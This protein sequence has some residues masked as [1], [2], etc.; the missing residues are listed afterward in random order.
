MKDLARVKSYMNRA[1]EALNPSKGVA[2]RFI[3]AALNSGTG[4][5]TVITGTPE[6]AISSASF[7]GKHTKFK[8]ENEKS[9]DESDDKK[10]S[11]KDEASIRKSSK[12]KLG[13]KIVERIKMDTATKDRR[14]DAMLKKHPLEMDYASDLFR[15]NCT[16]V[17]SK[18]VYEGLKPHRD[19]L[20]KNDWL[21]VYLGLPGKRLFLNNYERAGFSGAEL[22]PAALPRPPPTLFKTMEPK[23]IEMMKSFKKIQIELE[24]MSAGDGWD[25]IKDHY[26]MLADRYLGSS[27]VDV[28]ELIPLMTN[29]TFGGQELHKRDFFNLEENEIQRTVGAELNNISQILNV[30]CG[31]GT[32]YGFTSV[33]DIDFR[34]G[35]GYEGLDPYFQDFGPDTRPDFIIEDQAKKSSSLVQV[36]VRKNDLQRDLSTQQRES[37]KVRLARVWKDIKDPKNSLQL[38][39]EK[40]HNKRQ[41]ILANSE[42]A[43]LHIKLQ[44]GVLPIERLRNAYKHLSEVYTIPKCEMYKVL[45]GDQVLS[46]KFDSWEKNYEPCV[47]KVLNANPTT[48]NKT[49]QSIKDL[50]FQMFT[51]ETTAY[52]LIEHYNATVD[53]SEKINTPVMYVHGTLEMFE[54]N[55]STKEPRYY[56]ISEY[57]TNY[58][59]V[60]DVKNLEKLETQ[61]KLLHR[62]GIQHNAIDGSNILTASQKVYL[63]DFTKMTERKKYMTNEYLND[64]DEFFGSKDRF[65]HEQMLGKL[66]ISET[67]N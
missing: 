25:Y 3:E 48:A 29:S 62:L 61:L 30:H 55:G 5:S 9:D 22:N 10:V 15:K 6:P 39:R 57:I 17:T 45:K 67:D 52:K 49:G 34:F 59:Q 13:K 40:L 31:E 8:D 19:W 33:N 2:K 28:D 37:I 60:K 36:N 27:D 43:P 46:K 44:R 1:K 4:N 54:A 64:R 58:N 53:D 56:T 41:D 42:T 26:S 16:K 65:D 50:E 66:N 18:D 51:K 38:V 20:S 7:Q 47:L 32:K 14:I 12:E 21:N 23:E 63:I 11:K 24:D 35:E